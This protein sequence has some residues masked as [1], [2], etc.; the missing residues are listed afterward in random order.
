MRSDLDLA[1]RRRSTF[2]RSRDG[3]DVVVLG[4]NVA[5]Q[6]LEAGL[7]DEIIVQV[8]PV[9]VGEGVCFFERT[10]GEA[11]RLE[12]VFSVTRST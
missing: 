7:L 10:G 1:R 9:L 12:W 5:R 11:V 2:V 4:A 3:A 6:C 8:A